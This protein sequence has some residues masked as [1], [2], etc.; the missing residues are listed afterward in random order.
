MTT[1]IATL[2]GAL[3]GV[4]GTLLIER[5]RARKAEQHEKGHAR[6]EAYIAFVVAVH[7]TSGN[8]RTLA[9]KIAAVPEEEQLQQ[10]RDAFRSSGLYAAREHVVLVAPER[11]AHAAD[12]VF[13]ALRGLRQVV[14]EGGSVHE[15]AYLSEVENYAAALG[16]LRSMIRTDLGE[17][18]LERDVSW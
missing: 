1:L 5:N 2:L 10:A 8:L 3:I 15:L 4:V 11:I 18:P 6:A 7:A 17:V 16:H 14:A 9:L 13:V 12:A